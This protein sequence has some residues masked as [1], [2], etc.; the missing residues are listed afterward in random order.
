MSEN[1]K[2]IKELADELGVSKQTIR[3]KIDKDFREKFVQTIKIKGNNTLVI[4]NAGY[5]LLK[6]TLQNDTAQTA[7]TL[8]ND[9]AQTKLICFLEEQ[10]DKKEQQLSV[11]DK[12]LENKDTQISQM[13]NLL[14]QQQ[15]LALQDKKLLEEYKSEI[16]ELKALKMPRED[17]KDGSSIRGEAQ[18]EIE[19]LKAKLKL[20]EEERNKAKEKEPVK[21]ESKK[22]WHFGRM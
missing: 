3:N 14:D 18:E 10:L 8:Q 9:T 17:M 4:N 22:W 5:S 12:Q 7:K 2:T 15:R 1:L 21:T 20:S 6:K 11:K 19:R 16:N 13:Q